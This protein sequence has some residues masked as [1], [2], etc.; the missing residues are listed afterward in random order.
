M[1]GAGELCCYRAGQMN[2]TPNGDGK[3]TVKAAEAK[4]ELVVVRDDHSMVHLTWR[5]RS[6]AHASS[7]PTTEP[8]NDSTCFPDNQVRAH[9]LCFVRRA[10]GRPRTRRGAVT[11]RTHHSPHAW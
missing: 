1:L 10:G 7:T 6:S 4:G 11:Q 9:V 5:E 2:A 8:Q 3:F